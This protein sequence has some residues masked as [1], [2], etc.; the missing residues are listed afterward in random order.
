M[1]SAMVI[2]LK[3]AEMVNVTVKKKELQ[4]HPH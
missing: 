4:A 1:V 2:P 3:L